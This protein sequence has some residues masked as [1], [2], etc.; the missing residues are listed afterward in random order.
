MRSHAQGNFYAIFAIVVCVIV[1]GIGVG[2]FASVYSA[3]RHFKNEIRT[4]DQYH[5]KVG[6]WACSSVFVDAVKQR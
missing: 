4:L 3:R 1:I 6:E 5:A 2:I